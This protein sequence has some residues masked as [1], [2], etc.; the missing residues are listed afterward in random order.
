MHNL[1]RNAAGFYLRIGEDLINAIDRATR[2]PSRIQ[3]Q[4]N[5]LKGS[6]LSSE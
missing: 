4:G 2:Y 1:L 6:L 5:R 3:E